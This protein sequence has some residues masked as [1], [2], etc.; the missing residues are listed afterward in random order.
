MA[1]RYYSAY[2]GQDKVAVSET[3]GSTAAADVEVRIT[4]TAGTLANNKAGALIALSAI[5][6]RIIEDTWPPA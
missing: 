2:V 5:K 4:Y 3:A 1:D 6:Q